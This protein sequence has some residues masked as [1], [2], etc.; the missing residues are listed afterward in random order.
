MQI[1]SKVDAHVGTQMD[2]AAML[3]LLVSTLN[4][5]VRKQSETQKSNLSCGPS[6]SEKCKSLKTSQLA[7][8]ESIFLAW[9]KKACT[10]GAPSMDPTQRKRLYM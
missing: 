2:L 4:T 9:F 3:G 5:T 1:L 6:F 10:A 8:L 7:E